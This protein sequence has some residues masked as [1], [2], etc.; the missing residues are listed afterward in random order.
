MKKFTIITA[1]FLLMG[2]LFGSQVMA[3]GRIDLGGAKSAQNCANMTDE[4]FSAT[5]SFSSIESAEVTAEKGV[6]SN[7]TMENTY[8]S[9]MLGDPTLPAVNKLLAIPYGVGNISVEVK[10]FT[11]TVYSLA[12]FGI[13]TLYP[14]QPLLRKDQKPGDLPFAYNEK[15]YNAKGFAERPIAEVKI[16]GTLRGIQVGALTVNP[17]QYDAATNSIRVYN[18]IEVEVSYSQYDKSASYNEF[19]RT[20]SPYFAGI[21]SQMFNW[22]N[23]VYDEH[24]DLWQAPVKMLVIADRMFEECMQEWIAWKTK[25][26]FYMDVNYTDEIGNNASAI[27]S[28]I[29]QKYNED[30]PT[31]VMIMGDKNQ[32]APSATGNQTSCV[33]DLYYMSVDNDEF[34]DIFH[35]RFPAETVGQ[36]QAMLNKALEYEQFTMPDPSYLSNVLLIAGADPGWGITVGRP[37]IWY[38]TNYYYNT[39]H[40]FNQVHEYSHGTYS[41]CY[42]WLNEGVGFV[43]YTAHGSNTSWADP[44]LTISDVN[45]L[46]NEHKYF[47]AM[48]NCCQAA[49]WGISGSC[50]GE[51]MVRAENKAAYA[52]IGSCPSTYWLND[53]Y[54]AV[55]ATSHADGTMPTME[56][57]T[58]GCYDAIWTDDAFNTACA[59]PFIGNLASNAAQALG[60][61][62]HINTLYC[63]QAYHVLG[64]GSIMP[65]RVQP[66]P[67]DVTHLPTLP[68]GLDFYTVSAA[69]GSYVGITKDG[70]LHGAGLIGESGTADI[71][72][73]P[74]TSGGDVTICVT[75]PQHVPY[76]SEVPAAA[77]E[78]AYIACNGVQCEQPLITGAHVVPT[79]SLKNVGIQTANNIN[80][81]LSTES[82]YINLTHTTAT[83]PSI[84]PDAIYEIANTF[85][86][87]VAV[88]IPNNTKV[89]FFLTCTSGSD[90]WESKFDLTFGAPEFVMNNISNTQL[91]PGG[92]GTLNFDLT[93]AGAANAENCILEVYSSSN[94]ITLESNTIQINAIAAGENITIPVNLTVG[95]GVEIGTTYELSYLMTCG[96]YSLAGSYSATVGNIV[97]GFESGDFSM[98]DWQFGG[99]ANWTIVNNEANSGTYSAKS[100]TISDN[101]QTVLSLTTEILANG[102]VSFYKK[103]SSE[104][105]YD[106]LFFYIDDMEKGNWSGN[107]AWSKESYPVTAGTHTFKW[108]YKKDYSQSSGSDCAWVDDIQFPPTS[109]I[110]SLNPVTNLEANVNGY[111][112]ALTWSGSDDATAYIINRNGEEIANQ[113]GTSYNDNLSGDGIYTYSVI[114]TDGNGHYSAPAFVTV[115]VGTVGVEEM[116]VKEFGIY[117][118]PANNTL[119]ING[120]NTEFSYVLFNGMGQMVA[121]GKAQGSEQVN[122][123]DMAKGIYYLRITTG[124]QMRVE[125]VVVE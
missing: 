32:V 57:T 52:Y 38:A 79:V 31:F 98:Y 12:D 88:N 35:S 48:G 71:P 29:Q 87:D 97:E 8:P 99:P 116:N 50:F 78:G 56:E 59:I 74:I 27:R 49:D 7:I 85:D 80:V 118:N 122:V 47:L 124:T 17:V 115:N 1:A 51:A 113:S 14:Q 54:F 18:D 30:A 16:Q 75:H 121:N 61:E 73:E 100:G 83:V 44:Q 66:T 6:F 37:T 77:M 70:V 117:P 26:G 53:Y 125:K 103:V 81:V 20:F 101:Q 123:S 2:M 76:I 107:V 21:Y 40:G 58:M 46:T 34:A 39:E 93:N 22:R 95:S 119:N 55:G 91:Q 63:W 24:P 89:R 3:Q 104:T 109:V 28:F 106:K 67:N 65:F 15:A 9:G 60:Y 11:T 25:K 45:N 36:M 10:S 69:P 86:F 110:L 112:V 96:H 13:K 114:A 68:I 64:D 82:E 111:S 5:F 41:G 94:D 90:V 120:G 23:D 92:N 42:D 33:T 4:G 19:A 102:E 105:N 43:N 84:A 108:T 62:L 72:I